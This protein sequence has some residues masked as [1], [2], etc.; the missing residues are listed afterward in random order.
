[1]PPARSKSKRRK[2]YLTP[3]QYQIYKKAWQAIDQ[4]F[5]Q[6]IR[7]LEY[8]ELRYQPN[9]RDWFVQKMQEEGRFKEARRRA[10]RAQSGLPRIVDYDPKAKFRSLE[11][12]K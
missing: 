4:D 2:D 9:A 7:D 1:M 10:L 8:P 6:S 5:E 12:L 11:S 3:E